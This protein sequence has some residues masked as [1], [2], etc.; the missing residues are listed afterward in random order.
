LKPA[1]NYQNLLEQKTLEWI[2]GHPDFGDE[3]AVSSVLNPAGSPATDFSNTRDLMESPPKPDSGASRRAAR[4]A[5][6]RIRQTDF[7]KRDADNRTLGRLGEEWAVEFERYRLHDGEERQDLAKKVVWVSDDE[8]DGAGYDIR[9]FN[10]DGSPRLIEVKTTGLGKHF[11]FYVSAN[12]L[13]VSQ[14]QAN[15]Y[16]LYRVFRFA[17]APRLYA[18]NGPLDRVCSLTPEVF[19]ARPSGR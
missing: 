15:A 3:A 2:A 9:S 8:G 16:Y 12:E 11:P 10:R 14:Q 5:A 7:V 1:S 19:R 18:L 13:K 17:T 6:P 4:P